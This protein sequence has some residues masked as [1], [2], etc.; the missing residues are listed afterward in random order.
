M[1]AKDELKEQIRTLL[2]GRQECNHVFYKEGKFYASRYG[3]IKI[4]P[5]NTLNQILKVNPDCEVWR[6]VTDEKEPVPPVLKGLR[7]KTVIGSDAEC[8][9]VFIKLV[10]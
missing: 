5:H 7:Y 1:S 2:K 3:D 4:L 10:C 8:L 9:N 6:L